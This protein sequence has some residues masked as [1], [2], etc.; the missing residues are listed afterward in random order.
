MPGSGL[1]ALLL[2]AAA[3]VAFMALFR[4]LMS[5]DA[6]D[7]GFEHW[8]VATPGVRPAPPAMAQVVEATA[9]LPWNVERAAVAATSSGQ[10]IVAVEAVEGWALLVKR[11]GPSPDR[12]GVARV[13]VGADGW[14]QLLLSRDH[15]H[16]TAD[17]AMAALWESAGPWIKGTTPGPGPTH[18][19]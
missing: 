6:E 10:P 13:V 2:A 16:G 19:V 1:F 4:R 11:V 18:V 12:L 14:S 15:H 8:M 17:E 9:A 5:D 7:G 3:V